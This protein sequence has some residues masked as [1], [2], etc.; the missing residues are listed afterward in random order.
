[1]KMTNI[2]IKIALGLLVFTACRSTKNKVQDDVPACIRSF[3]DSFK[4]E[5]KQNPP[6]SVTEYIYKGRKV[7]YVPSPC[8][9]QFNPVFDSDCKYLG[10]PGG[11]FTGRGDGKI[12]DFFD[13]AKN[14]K[15]I[16]KDE[17]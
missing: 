8:C 13:S 7:Y 5:P 2:L 6:R 16:W 10:S 1:M 4:T 17:R 3:I 9:D 15:L 12:S 11:G 14:E